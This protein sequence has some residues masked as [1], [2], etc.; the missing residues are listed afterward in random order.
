MSYPT[1][2][3]PI[4]SGKVI[5]VYDGDTITILSKVPGLKNS[6]E[7]KFQIRLN[8]IDTPELRTKNM[9]EKEVAQEAQVALSNIILDK[10]VQ[11]TVLKLDKYGRLLCEVYYN[12]LCMNDWMLTKHFAVEYDGGTK[13]SPESWRAYVS[14]G[15]NVD[16]P[17]LKPKKSYWFL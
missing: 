3:P 10:I 5:K 12:G 6:Q 17:L 14:T 7:Y 13:K 8:R 2:V 9:E 1:F 15:T 16:I 11:L 4:V